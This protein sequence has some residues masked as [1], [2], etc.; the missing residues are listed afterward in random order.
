MNGYPAAA[1]IV[2]V[3]GIVYA[4]VTNGSIGELVRTDGTVGG[5]GVVL[6]WSTSVVDG[7]AS[8]NGHL[9]FTLR[10]QLYA[11]DGTSAG[12][13]A[14]LPPGVGA[15]S[16]FANVRGSLYFD[17]GTAA[18]GTELWTTDGTLAGTRMVQDINP[19]TQTYY[20][21]YYGRLVT[22]GLSSAPVSFTPVY[23]TLYFTAND[24]VHG[25]ELWK[26]DTL[27]PPEVDITGPNAGFAGTTQSLTLAAGNP[28]AAEKIA[29]F[30]YTIDWG[31]G[32]RQPNGSLPTAVGPGSGI[33]VTHTY[34]QA[35]T[36]PVTVTATDPN[37]QT[38]PAA[39][40][41]IVIF[42]SL[43]SPT[44]AG[45][46]ASP[47]DPALG[48]TVLFQASSAAQAQAILAAANGLDRTATPVSTILLDLTGQTIQSA[49]VNVPS[50]VTLNMLNGMFTGGSSVLTAQSGKI[51]VQNSSFSTTADAPTIN[52]AGA[53]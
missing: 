30:T 5:T 31:D 25:R 28:S 48:N 34:S 47:I 24:G 23:G 4:V 50:Q 2:S 21:S 35:G 1:Q 29:S 32:T 33:S 9:F 53:T 46:L 13:Q 42:S 38:G 20:S 41:K 11:S 16:Y 3:N 40:Y 27:S 51:I 22:F 44:L 26:L 45:L 49:V 19:N 37:G 52:V 15:F 6:P 7:L 43:D 36:Y 39:T 10:G 12:T 18:T 8:A 17:A 14:L